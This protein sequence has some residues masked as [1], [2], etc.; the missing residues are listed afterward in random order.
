MINILKHCFKPAVIPVFMLFISCNQDNSNEVD[1][2]S[3]LFTSIPASYSGIS[4]S[5]DLNYTER[6]NPFTYH[7]FYNGGGV[8]AGDINNDGL[9]DL[10]FCSNQGSNKLYLNKGNFK[11]EDITDKAGVGSDG[12]W[13]T[14]VTFVDINGDGLL[15]IFVCRANDFKVGFRGNQLFINN[16]D[17]TF[18]EKAIEYGLANTGGSVQAAFFDYDNDGD[19]DCYLLNYPSRSVGNDPL[20]KNQRKLLDTKGGNKLMRNDGGHFTDVTASAG[21]Y[22]SVIGFGLGVS[23]ADINK[24]G[25]PDIYVSND[26]FERDYLYINKQ[27]GT[28]EESLEKYIREISMFSMGAE[29]ADI[30]NDGWPDIFVTDMLPEKEARVKTKTHFDD[31]EKYQ[32]NLKNGY[33][34]QFLRNVLQVNNGPLYKYADTAPEFHFSE[35]GRFAGVQATDWSWGSLVADLDNDGYKDIYVSNGM[36]KDVSDQDFMEY[37]ANSS[38][39]KFSVSQKKPGIK[40]LIDMLPSE[41]IAKYAFHNNGD[42]TFSDKAAEWGLDMHGFSNGSLYVDLDNDGDLDLVTN[43]VNMAASVYRNNSVQL[44]PENKFL[45]IVLQGDGKN[46]NGFGSKVTAYYNHTLSYMEENPTRGFLSC[47]DNRLNFGLGKIKIIDSLKIEWPG[48]KEQ[49]LKNVLPNQ[50]LIVKQSEAYFPQKNTALPEAL[51][52]F[53]QQKDNAGIDYV[54]RQEDFNDFNKYRLMHHMVSYNGPR[55]AKADVN[56]DGLEDIFI[57][58]TEKHPGALYLQTKAG[59]FIQSK[60]PAFLIDSTCT[61]T[62]CVFFDADGDGDMDLFVCSGG[63]EF[64]DNP[65]SFKNRLYINNGKGDFSKSLQGL[66]TLVNGE[67]SSCVSAADYDNDGDVDLFVGIQ[68][69]TGHY[70][71]PCKGYILQNNGKGIFTDVTDEVAP[72]LLSAG[73][74]TDAKWFD[75]D[76]DGK[77]DLVMTGE[78]MPVRV[79]HNINGRLEEVTSQA[80]M[81]SSNGWWNHLEIADVNG[82]GYPDII[83]GNYGLNSRFK[84]SA[85]KPVTMYVSDFDNNGTVEQVVCTFNGEKQY[86]LALRHDMVGILPSLK[87]KF[88]KYSDYKEKTIEDI[89]SSEQLSNAIKLDAYE[90]RSGI[91]LNDGR[92]HFHFQPLPA[93]AQYSSL[94]GIAFADFDHDGNPDIL[95]G[96]NF[97]QCKPE[98]GI[99]DGSYG[100]LLK[101]NGKGKFVPVPMSQSDFF[102]E[103]AIRDIKTIKCPK[104]NLAIVARNHETPVVFQY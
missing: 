96:G 37:F 93:A 2:P 41:P 80:G 94:Y 71:Y 65:V 58:G 64:T 42:L 67:S 78:Y 104:S 32:V 34:H 52:V 76:N 27:D 13:S 82:D 54:H 57:C 23:I 29:I 74:I 5:N 69:K 19:L 95:L 8:A 4:F 98:I 26:F 100:L 14:G 16:G 92:G 83:A 1:H 24:D 10:F 6:L 9:P 62:D 51:P 39:H 30:N 38:A 40:E 21:I 81:A 72:A 7:N 45:K 25:W 50:T 31:W 33:Y 70:G 35:I 75:Y 86:P 90:L 36:Y 53:T 84:A 3:R 60:Q 66:P 28:F 85:D 22:G 102:V 17:L 55:M 101:G 12:L 77:P 89:F 44:H 47:V 99:Q 63:N 18:T 68:S 49:V 97:Y 59:K 11:F 48:G 87:K 15:D 43:N 91:W 73:I 20:V 88:L 103:G 56:G 46:R 61:D 79:F